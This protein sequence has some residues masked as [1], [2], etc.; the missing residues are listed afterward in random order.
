MHKT[1]DSANISQKDMHRRPPRQ[2]VPKVRPQTSGPT[3]INFYRHKAASKEVESVKSA[4][5]MSLSV[6]RNS[7]LQRTHTAASG[8]HH[9]MLEN[10][11][12]GKP[13]GQGAYATVYACYHKMN[14][15]KFAIK[16]Y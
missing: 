12:I 6:D 7:K 1:F 5:V 15:R 11:Q 13:I 2:D 8:S 9:S 16:I 3:S 14:M 10:Y 4:A